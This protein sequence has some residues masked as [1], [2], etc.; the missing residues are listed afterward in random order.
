LSPTAIDIIASAS[1]DA[2][3]AAPGAAPLLA[4]RFM[5]VLA[6][7]LRQAKRYADLFSKEEAPS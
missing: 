2:L 1:D 4:L 5:C 6:L 7:T 3:E